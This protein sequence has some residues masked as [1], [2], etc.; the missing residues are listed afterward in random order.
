MKA[1][2]GDFVELEL[3]N[4]TLQGTLMPSKNK[5]TII[6]LK[7]GYNISIDETAS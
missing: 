6:K 2:V 4:E 5:K 3:K 1:K 7:S